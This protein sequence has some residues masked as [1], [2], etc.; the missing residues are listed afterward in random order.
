MTELIKDKW[1]LIPTIILLGYLL[2]R[3]I[4]QSSII[5]T[6]PLDYTND[7]SSYITQL[8]FL[9]VCGFHEFCPYWYGG[10]VAFLTSAPGWPFFTYPLYMIVGNITAASYTALVLTYIISLLATIKIGKQLRFSKLRTMFLF[11]FYFG[12]SIAIGDFIRLGRVSS[13]LSFALGLW[14]LYFI[15]KYRDRKLTAGFLIIIPI[16]AALIL[17]H[18]QEAFLFSISFLSLIAY[19]KSLVERGIII[20]SVLLA[21]I[22]TLF[23][24]YPF[25]VDALSG[26]GGS[27]LSS[28]QGNWVF[29]LDQ[30]LLPTVIVSAIIPATFLI[31]LAARLK[32]SSAWKSQLRFYLPIVLL[33]ILFLTRISTSVPFLNNI[34]PDPINMFILLFILIL[35]LELREPL[36][37]FKW[38]AVTGIFLISI[39]SVT[40]SHIHTPYFIKYGET[41]YGILDVLEHTDKPYLI[42]NPYQ[43]TSYSNAYYSLGAVKYNLTT[44]AGWYPFIATKEQLSKLETIK[45]RFENHDCIELKQKLEDVK[46]ERII[47]YGEYCLK[48]RYCGFKQIRY[49]KTHKIK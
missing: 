4:N 13:A 47:G 16:Y 36:R 49:L 30:K 37:S 24:T 6:F 42:F 34:S 23:W 21:L 15:L 22:A 48:L 43:R 12:N 32:N 18:Y 2:I 19:K 29:K 40:I 44:P 11:A 45:E 39:A 9:R 1:L 35:L 41:E 25:A 7:W 27:I 14:V 10:F 3:F 33:A 26:T 17:T 31:I 38:I 8:H 46:T 5:N 20:L 28:T